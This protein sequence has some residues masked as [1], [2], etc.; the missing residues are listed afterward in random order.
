MA[1]MF[2]SHRNG[3]VHQNGRRFIVLGHK[4]CVR[5]GSLDFGIEIEREIRKRIKTLR[6]LFLDFLFTVE[7][8]IRKRIWKTVL[9]N[10]GFLHAHA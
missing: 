10:S 6:Y 5:L 3:L 4:G 8:E 1:K 2:I 9:K 7:W